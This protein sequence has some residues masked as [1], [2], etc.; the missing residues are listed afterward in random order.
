MHYVPPLPMFIF[1]SV[2]FG[3]IS[4]LG[5]PT[6]T[7]IALSVAWSQ[8]REPLSTLDLSSFMFIDLMWLAFRDAASAPQLRQTTP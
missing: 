1:L 6:C 8:S 2:V 7:S 5:F 3:D 4:Q